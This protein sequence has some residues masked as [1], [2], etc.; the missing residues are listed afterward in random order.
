MQ[1]T[2]KEVEE[3]LTIMEDDKSSADVSNLSIID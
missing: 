2:D 3:E 1:A